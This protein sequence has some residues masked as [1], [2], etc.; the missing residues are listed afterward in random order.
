MQYSN[1]TEMVFFGQSFRFSPTPNTEMIT[2]VAAQV[3]RVKG[4]CNSNKVLMDQISAMGINTEMAIMNTKIIKNAGRVVFIIAISLG[5]ARS[6]AKRGIPVNQRKRAQKE[7]YF[8]WVS[9]CYFSNNRGIACRST[10]CT[11]VLDL[12][13]FEGFG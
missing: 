7:P 3:S 1:Y 6:I 5:N 2:R 8:Q 4:I 12:L 13:R 10:V 11:G 9:G